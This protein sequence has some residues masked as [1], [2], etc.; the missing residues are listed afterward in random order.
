[1]HHIKRPLFFIS[2]I[3][4]VTAPGQAYAFS[5]TQVH[6]LWQD[7]A[8]VSNN[9]PDYLGPT[10]PGWGLF[11]FFA[12]PVGP[13]GTYPTYEAMCDSFATAQGYTNTTDFYCVYDAQMSSSSFGTPCF[14]TAC[15]PGV[16]TIN[17]YNGFVKLYTNPPTQTSYATI[18]AQLTAL[19]TTWLS[20][21][22]LGILPN[23][24]PTNP[25]VCDRS[26]VFSGLIPPLGFNPPNSIPFYDRCNIYHHVG[27]PSS[28]PSASLSA[29]PPTVTA[30][31]SALLTY[32]CS[33]GATSATIDNGVGSVTPAA[34]GS[35]PVTPGSTTT[36]SL[37]C[38]N[39]NGASV[40]AVTTVTVIPLPTLPDLT[41]GAIS[42]TTA[43]AGQSTSLSAPVSNTGNG[44][45]GVVFTDLFQS[46]TDSSGSNATDIGTYPSIALPASIGNLALL[47]YTFPTAGTYYLRACADK[48]S[49]GSPGVISESN[50]LGTA[51]TNNCGPWT[52]VTVASAGVPS[53]S[54]TPSNANPPVGG[55]VIYTATVGGGAG[56]PFTWNPSLPSACTASTGS[57]ISCTFTTAG[58]Y[59]MNV[60]ATGVAGSVPCSPNPIQVGAPS[61]AVPAN[62]TLTPSMNRVRQGTGTTISYNVTGGINTSCTITGPGAPGTIN[63]NACALNPSSG[64]F[65]TGPLN[66][67]ATYIIRCDGT[68]LS[69]TIVNIIPNF[70]EF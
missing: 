34:G 12:D 40:P 54:C 6:T 11:P 24:L 47:S 37:V 17:I 55:T 10:F 65:S 69:R 26:E 48:S 45:T 42:P 53:V 22:G 1:M 14:G 16:G 68:E 60:S 41:T 28:V 15:S 8:Y 13:L 5:Y 44:A 61:C 36:Y 20:N 7:P 32:T 56:A 70:K 49:S 29:T 23:P 39:A 64:S 57:T 58:L 19:W 50:A 30:G 51:E 33:N 67:Q 27:M 18:S 43:T 52:A 35:V 2:F 9:A 46:A 38:T 62:A 66:S 4:L 21:V 3:L 25:D 63:A 59:A 31:S